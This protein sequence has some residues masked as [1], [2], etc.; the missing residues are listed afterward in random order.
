MVQQ[1]LFLGRGYIKL[2]IKNA[3]FQS[4][5]QSE[6]YSIHDGATGCKCSKIHIQVRTYYVLILTA[7]T[8]S[9]PN[10]VPLCAQLSVQL[11][12]TVSAS[13]W[14]DVEVFPPL[15]DSTRFS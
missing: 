1:N 8:R 13:A 5:V 15:L 12:A 2:R 7:N 11:F 10:T 4:E 9:A 3:V 14:L 6:D